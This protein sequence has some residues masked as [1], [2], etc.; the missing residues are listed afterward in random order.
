MANGNLRAVVRVI[1]LAALC[2]AIWALSKYGYARPEVLA[3]NAPATE[4]SAGRAY[5][6]LGR[7]LGPEKPHP[8]STPE[9]AAVR[10]RIQAEFARLGVKT[11]TYTAFA[12]N[13]WRGFNYIPC[14]T[15][16]DVLAE[17]VPG[18]G[19][20]IVLLAHY[21]SVP[22]GPGA[23]DDE[24]GV[25]IVLET[26]RA[27]RARGA[28]SLHP[29]LAVITDGE[30]AG[31][32]GA[33]AF[34]E[35][36]ALK[37]RVGAVVNVEARGTRGRSL[38]FQTS[39]GDSALIDLY[40]RS[41]PFY[42]TSSLF[43]EIYRAL[44]NASVLLIRRSPIDSCFAMYRTLFGD[45]YPFTYDF[46]DLARYYAAYERLI[47]HWRNALGERLREV[48]YEDLVREPKRI[49]QTLAQ[50]CGLGWSDA[51][52]EIQNNQAVSLTASAAQVRRPIYGSSSGRWRHYHR[53]L[54]GL[55]TA[56]RRYGVSLPE[57]A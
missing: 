32:L 10:A 26:A 36:A 41:V 37:A 49:G 4:F 24:S 50:Y 55:I 8:V 7:L 30:E 2:V 57:G 21:D 34:L 14:A 22:A 25:S 47:K 18:Q 56:L 31:L 20:A 16:T 54:G 15:V 12:C 1:A 33:Q 11:S 45:A 13:A 44:P 29:V 35:N 3:E 23:S 5:A 52:L 19:K 40:A 27:L 46:E 17:I 53:H 43:A 9:N 42:S 48:V 38:L 39:P 28:K 51:A 6:T